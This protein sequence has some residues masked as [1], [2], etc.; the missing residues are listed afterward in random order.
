MAMPVVTKKGA[1][2]PREGGTT[3]QA[4][5]SGGKACFAANPGDKGCK[6][7][8]LRRFTA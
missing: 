1:L 3:A 5:E 4:A 6:G 8:L 7:T 2:Q